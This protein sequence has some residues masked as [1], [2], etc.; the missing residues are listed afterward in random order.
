M[1]L[2]CLNWNQKFGLFI[3]HMLRW[4]KKGDGFKEGYQPLKIRRL[5]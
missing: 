3:K 4:G 2:L 5:D 1:D